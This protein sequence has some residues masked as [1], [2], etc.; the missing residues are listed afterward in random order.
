[1][2]TQTAIT[3]C[4]NDLSLSPNTEETYKHG[5]SRFMEYLD[6]Q[7]IKGIDESTSI[8]MDHFISF[9]PW[10]SRR[11][12]KQTAGVYGS[13][14]KSF[15]EWM[16]M[17]GQLQPSY[18]EMLRYQKAVKRSHKRHED[19]LP[20]WP[21]RDDV[22]KVLQAV[23]AYNEES[24]R[25][26]RNIAL[27]ELLASSGCRISEITNLNVQDIDLENQTAVVTGKGSKERRVFFSAAAVDAIK[28]Y[29][30]VRQSAKAN[31]PILGRHDKG[32]GHKVVKRI[33]NVTARNIVHDIAVIA[34]LDPTKF[35]P[36]Y[37]RHAFAIRIL[38]ETGN[39]ALVQDLM[40]HA[41]P[42]STRVYAKIY[43]DDLQSIHR[44]IYG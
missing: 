34:G 28:E 4:L 7:G 1:M 17:D 37:F 19:R 13:A 16:I 44:K 33:T 39:L 8:K 29:W 9:L 35:T 20:R 2:N 3:R 31:D 15:L 25:K 27:L 43:P 23:H 26:E 18:Q 42:N 32:A 40:G 21:Q 12:T 41:S 5:L 36:H 22:E 6:E 14:S 30:K 11:Y 10:L 24:P 38:S